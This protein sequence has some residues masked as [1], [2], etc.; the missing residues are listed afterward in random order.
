MEC[1]TADGERRAE[2]EFRSSHADLSVRSTRISIV[3]DTRHAVPVTRVVVNTPEADVDGCMLA[4]PSS[5]LSQLGEHVR[6]RGLIFVDLTSQGW[7]GE[8]TG[9]VAGIQLQPLVENRLPHGVTGEASV[10]IRQAVF[11][12]SRLGLIGGCQCWTRQSQRGLLTHCDRLGCSTPKSSV[13]ENNTADAMQDYEQF[14]LMV[15]MTQ[16]GV[17]VRGVCDPPRDGSIIMSRFGTLLKDRGRNERQSTFDVIA[18]LLD[19]DHADV[20][21]TDK[22]NGYGVGCR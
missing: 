1:T 11:D 15:D 12:N 6:F 20:L 4:G 17:I 22:G 2:I 16:Q 18:A 9:H 8:V 19:N 13:S 7:Q 5:W 3:R 14:A 21:F 10:D